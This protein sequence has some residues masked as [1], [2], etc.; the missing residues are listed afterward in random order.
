MY[1]LSSMYSRAPPQ[2]IDSK[3]LAINIDK[4][5]DWNAKLIINGVIR[6]FYTVLVC[7]HV[8]MKRLKKYYDRRGIH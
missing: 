7:L 4:A 2:R 6:P 3:W 5:A 1:M 8:V